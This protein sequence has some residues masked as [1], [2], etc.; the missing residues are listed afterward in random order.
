MQNLATVSY[1]KEQ[2][3]GSHNKP[4]I[5]DSV[6]QDTQACGMSQVIRMHRENLVEDR[7]YAHRGTKEHHWVV[8]CYDEHNDLDTDS[9]RTRGRALQWLKEITAALLE[10][11]HADPREIEGMPPTASGTKLLPGRHL[12]DDL[13]REEAA[14][15]QKTQDPGIQCLVAMAGFAEGLFDD[16]E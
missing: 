9:S 2:I 10:N 5:Q 7:C 15:C 13:K 6:Y 12:F 4:I 3:T 1:W 8:L 16:D 11:P 14:C